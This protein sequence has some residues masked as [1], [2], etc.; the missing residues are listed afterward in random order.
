[1]KS[2]EIHY[3]RD[4]HAL[5]EELLVFEQKYGVRRWVHL[6]HQDEFVNFCSR[7]IDSSNQKL[8]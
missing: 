4:I 6:F 3:N 7:H 8:Y 5:E 2:T 1:M